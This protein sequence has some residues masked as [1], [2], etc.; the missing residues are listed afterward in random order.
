MRSE[1]QSSGQSYSH[2]P[3]SR[4]IFTLLGLHARGKL[5]AV[6]D[7]RSPRFSSLRANVV[8]S[9]VDRH[10]VLLT[11]VVLAGGEFLRKLLQLDPLLVGLHNALQGSLFTGGHLPG[12]VVDVDVFLDRNLPI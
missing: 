9:L 10:Q 12:Q 1:K 6:E 2:A 5:E 4:E 11:L 3:S 8:Q 7:V